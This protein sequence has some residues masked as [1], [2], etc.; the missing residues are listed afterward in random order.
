MTVLNSKNKTHT[1][2][3]FSKGSAP[4]NPKYFITRITIVIEEE[5][6]MQN[7][8]IRVQITF[9]REN[10]Y[11]SFK[12]M[13]DINYFLSLN[14]SLKAYLSAYFHYIQVKSNVYGCISLVLI[15][16]PSSA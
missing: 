2:I 13:E 16:A 9:C 10:V 4:T 6:N 8:R 11:F 14:L 5:N 1:K 12:D 15:Y 7:K 3:C